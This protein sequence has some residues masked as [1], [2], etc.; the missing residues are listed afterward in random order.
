MAR[1]SKPQPQQSAQKTD[2]DQAQSQKGSY[3]IGAAKPERLCTH[4]GEPG[5][6]KHGV[7]T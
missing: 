4:C 2:S 5:H 1:R 7:M 3:E 6:T